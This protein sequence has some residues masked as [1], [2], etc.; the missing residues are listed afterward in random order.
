MGESSA[1][2]DIPRGPGVTLGSNTSTIFRLDPKLMGFTIAKHKF[3]GK[4]FDGFDSVLEIGCMDGFGSR[5]IQ[6]HVKKLCCIDFYDDHIDEAKKWSGLEHV[7][8]HKCDFL[9]GPPQ[10]HFKPERFDNRFDGILALDVLEHVDPLQEG[11]FLEMAV[12][13]LLPSGVFIVG[14]P[15]LESQ[16]FASKANVKAHINCQ[17]PAQITATL[18]EYFANV[19][20]FGF[21]D[22]VLHT[23][24][25]PMRH[26]Q[27]NICAGP[28][29]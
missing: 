11:A 22:E 9:D 3:V 25:E 21:N 6:P 18:K 8:F 23:G 2:E 13:H 16:R 15:T 27:M 4:M 29:K 14:M 24:Y 19:F 26:Y 5:I 10:I 12:R 20:S 17:H 1:E 7:T 28:K